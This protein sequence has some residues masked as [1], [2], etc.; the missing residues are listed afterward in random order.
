MGDN[1]HNVSC[2]GRHSR[3]VALCLLCR[4]SGHW[5][6]AFACFGHKCVDSTRSF[7]AEVHRSRSSL[8]SFDWRPLSFKFR[9]GLAVAANDDTG[10]HSAARCNACHAW[11]QVA[12]A[13]RFCCGGYFFWN[14]SVE[15][16]F[17]SHGGGV[18]R[19]HDSR[20]VADV[21]DSFTPAQACVADWPMGSTCWLSASKQVWGWTRR[22]C[23]YLK[24]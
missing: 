12:D 23:A 6:A 21:A 11:H 9:P 10:G 16:V 7:F 5:A 3:R 13:R 8:A 22:S 18:C 20:D 17:H 24:N 2:D 4:R 1:R 14:L 15:S 19:L